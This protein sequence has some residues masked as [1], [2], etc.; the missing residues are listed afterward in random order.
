MTRL[1]LLVAASFFLAQAPPARAQTPRERAETAR[2]VA[3]F[4]NPDGGFSGSVGGKPSLGS[5]S[6]VIRTLTYTGGSIKDVLGAIAYVESCHDK[7][8]GGFAP[9]P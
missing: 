1:P 6:S 3:A 2:Y 5:T 8:S 9:T 7:E 4:Q